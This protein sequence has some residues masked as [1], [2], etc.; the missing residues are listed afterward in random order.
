M[1][2]HASNVADALL[3][4]PRETESTN[5][6]DIAQARCLLAELNRVAEA[7]STRIAVVADLNRAHVANTTSDVLSEAELQRD[8]DEAKRLVVGILR[9]FPNLESRH[10]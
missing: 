3:P 8:L 2:W 5:A 7:L 9:R 6:A 10:H 4:R 1:L